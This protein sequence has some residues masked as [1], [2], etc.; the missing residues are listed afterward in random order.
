MNINE[1]TQPLLM[2]VHLTIRMEFYVH[3]RLFNKRTN[4]NGLPAKWSTNCSSNVWFVCTPTPS[5]VNYIYM[6]SML[7]TITKIFHKIIHLK[8]MKLEDNTPL[9]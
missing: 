3:V 7:N 4:T 2:Y 5:I 6:D 9:L 8:K 1:R